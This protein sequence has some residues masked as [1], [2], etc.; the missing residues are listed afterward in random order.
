MFY[1]FMINQPMHIYRYAQSHIIILHHYVSG[2]PLCYNKNTI[3]IQITE[4]KSMIKPLGI[5]LIFC[6]APNG[7]EVLNYIIIKIQ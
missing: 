5:S 7:H 1:T 3:N 6:S 4:Q 2:T